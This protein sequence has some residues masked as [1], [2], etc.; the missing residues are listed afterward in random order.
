[1]ATELQKNL[2]Q[3]IVKN[4]KR[5]KPLNKKELLV[6]SG[7]AELSAESVPGKIINQKGVQ[8][9]LKVLG[10]DEDSAK[11]VVSEIMLNPDAGASERL[12]ATDQ[13]FKVH[14][15]YASE[16]TPIT[17][18][19]EELELTIQQTL[20]EFRSH[21]RGENILPETPSSF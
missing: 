20:N 5:K 6:S 9:E 17:I 15:S 4:S 16:K 10:F 2:A 1:M 21:T 8:E 13:V 18:N 19:I 14:G 3:Q 11:K 7:Y 12:K